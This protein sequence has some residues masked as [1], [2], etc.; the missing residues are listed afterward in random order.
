MTSALGLAAKTIELLGDCAR[1]VA[2]NNYP[3]AHTGSM[4]TRIELDAIGGPE[5]LPCPSPLR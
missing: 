3:R 2:R 5:G 4:H 1:K